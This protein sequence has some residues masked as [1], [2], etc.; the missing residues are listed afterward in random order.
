MVAADLQD[1]MTIQ[2]RSVATTP[3]TLDWY[4][5]RRAEQLGA[6]DA[7][8]PQLAALLRRLDAIYLFHTFGFEVLMRPTVAFSCPSMSTGESQM[9]PSHGG[10]RQRERS[11]YCRSSSPANGGRKSPACSRLD[12]QMFGPVPPVMGRGLYPWSRRGS[13]AMSAGRLA[14]FLMGLPNVALELWILDRVVEDRRR[15]HPGRL[16]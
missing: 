10:A 1:N 3:G 11:V 12:P 7:S 13:I 9:R 15:H 2:L 14:G 5:Q 6:Y 8:N 4:K 16:P